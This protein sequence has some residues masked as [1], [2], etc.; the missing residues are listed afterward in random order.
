MAKV[1]LCYPQYYHCPRV[2]SANRERPPPPSQG[3][4]PPRPLL[5]LRNEG[6]LVRAEWL[7]VVTAGRCEGWHS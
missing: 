3:E 7:V 4:K 1:V 2:T 6:E 5:G